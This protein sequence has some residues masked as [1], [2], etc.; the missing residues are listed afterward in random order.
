[1]NMKPK[2]G[3]KTLHGKGHV[4]ET[5]PKSVAAFLHAHAAALDKTVVGDYLGKE[6]AYQ[7]G[8]CVKVLHEYVDAM[9]FTGLEFDV[10]I[11][12]FLSGFRLPGEAQK[13]D[14]MMEKYAERYCALN[15]AVFPSADV[16]FV[17]A[18]SVI[19]LQTDLHNPAVKEEKKMTKEGFRRNNRG[20]CNG[21][22]LDGA[23]LDEIFDRIKLAPIT[24]AED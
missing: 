22:D 17:L 12:H 23:F 11:R 10:A 5:D 13:I 4:D 15:K 9:D 19:M 14:R 24:L 21:A 2:H 16:A 6:E 3:L 18:F 7:D 20:I 1:F 8:F